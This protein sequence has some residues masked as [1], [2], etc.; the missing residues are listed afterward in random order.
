MLPLM[1]GSTALP[2]GSALTLAFEVY[3]PNLAGETV[4]F[5]VR[6]ERTR[7]GALTRL[8]RWI[9]LGGSGEE[10]AVAWEEAGP[11]RSRPLFRS[12]A[13]TL[14][15]LDAGPYQVVVELQAPGHQPLEARRAFRITDTPHTAAAPSGPAPEDEE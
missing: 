1:R 15:T 10:A 13:M 8:V 6:V 7:V 5:R 3:G 4:A 9:G 12:L 11:D 2:G 14:P